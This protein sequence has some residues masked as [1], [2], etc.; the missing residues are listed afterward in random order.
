M[1]A[2]EGGIVSSY[3]YTDTWIA[4]P[5]RDR[6]NDGLVTGYLEK[7]VSATAQTLRTIHIHTAVTVSNY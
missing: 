5:P 4:R 6:F 7:N 2:R 3:P 1:T